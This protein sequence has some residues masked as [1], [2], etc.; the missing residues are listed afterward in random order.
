MRSPRS[1]HRKQ[2]INPSHYLT[3]SAVM[4]LSASSNTR[5]YETGLAT[6]I[7][8]ACLV[9]DAF[10]TTYLFVA[11]ATLGTPTWPDSLKWLYDVPG[12]VAG[13]MNLQDISLGYTGTC[14]YYQV[15]YHSEASIQ[16]NLSLIQ[17][18]WWYVVHYV[19]KKLLNHP[20]TTK[21]V[22]HILSP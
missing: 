22:I 4:C 13:D 21:E 1:Y 14:T 20:S 8:K 19:L 12:S 17:F 11:G 18:G 5:R 9:E 3:I 6:E 10:R 2:L 7:P 15:L 16:F